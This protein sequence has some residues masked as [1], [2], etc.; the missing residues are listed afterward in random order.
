MT[1]GPRLST[2]GPMWQCLN[3]VPPKT[4][5]EFESVSG[6]SSCLNGK[7][8]AGRETGVCIEGVGHTDRH[9]MEE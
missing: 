4:D 5:R 1:G 6:G 2:C 7:D 8:Q 3:A 9:S